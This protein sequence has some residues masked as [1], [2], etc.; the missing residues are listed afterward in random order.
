NI[1][2]IFGKMSKQ[3]FKRRVS[4][5]SKLAEFSFASSQLQ[6]ILR[7]RAAIFGN[8]PGIGRHHMRAH[9]NALANFEQFLI[10]MLVFFRSKPFFK[11]YFYFFFCERWKRYSRTVFQQLGLLSGY[12]FCNCL[13]RAKT[14]NKNTIFTLASMGWQN[15]LHLLGRRNIIENNQDLRAILIG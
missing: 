15:T 6:S 2:L 3:Y 10:V 5:T 13:E 7:R 14:D 12:L 4:C 11:Q 1:A 8:F 9:L